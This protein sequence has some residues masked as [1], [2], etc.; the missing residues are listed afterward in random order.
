MKQSIVLE[1]MLSLIQLML[2]KSRV[3]STLLIELLTQFQLTTTSNN[4][5]EHLPQTVNLS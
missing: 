3:F 2:T 1:L 4:L 5:W